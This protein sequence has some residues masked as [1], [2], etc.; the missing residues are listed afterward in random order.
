[1]GKKYWK[2][3]SVLCTAGLLC[4]VQAMPVFA[5]NGFSYEDVSNLTFT[6]SSGVGAWGTVLEIDEKGAFEGFFHDAN[7]GETGE[8]YPNGTVYVCDFSGQFTEPVKVNDYTY[9]VEIESLEYEKEADTSEIVDGVLYVNS[10]P[11]GL[12]HAEQFLFYLQGAPLAELPDEYRSW[13]G[14][15]DLTS[16]EETEL[17]FVGF[18]NEDAEEGFRSYEK[19]DD[20]DGTEMSEI[21]AELADIAAQ[22]ED[23]EEQLESGMLAQQEMNRLSA[24]LYIL[25]DEELNSMWKRIKEILPEDAM[26]LLTEEELDWIWEKEAAVKEAGSEAEGG[27]LQPL[28]EN[29]TAVEYTRERVYELAEYLR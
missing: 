22:A 3:M 8:G 15:Y 6:F 2:C 16:V 5:E 25:W 4:G 11:Y 1:M 23:M 13:V 10:D 14:Y 24:E 18:Y 9:S 17:P 29:T 7:M 12:D 19:M 20:A 27:T 26:D 28:L 21:D